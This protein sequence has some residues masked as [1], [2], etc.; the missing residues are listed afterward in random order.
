MHKV[1]VGDKIKILVDRAARAIV[2]KGEVLKVIE[3]YEN[4]HEGLF[5]AQTKDGN[6]WSFTNKNF[7]YKSIELVQETEQKENKMKTVVNYHLLNNS[8]VLNYGGKTLSISNDDPRYAKVIDC[9]R[10]N[11][12]EAIPG[13]VEVE[14]AF[15][16]T[17]LELRDGLL[18][19]GEVPFPIELSDRI[20]KHK[21]AGLPYGPLVKF[22][23]NLKKNPS[24]N[25][26]MMM[27]KF[28]EHNGIPLTQDG[29]FIAYRGIR[30]DFKDKRTGTFDNSPGSVCSM[31]REL[32]DDNPN[33]TCSAG[34]HVACYGYAKDFGEKL[35]EVKVNPFDVVAVPT[36]YQGTKMRTCKFEVIQ[37]CAEELNK[38]VYDE[39]KSEEELKEFDNIDEEFG[40]I[41]DAKD[42]FEQEEW[43]G[44]EPSDEEEESS[45]APVHL[46][47][48]RAP[49]VKSKAP[50]YRHAKRDKNGKFVAKK[51]KKSK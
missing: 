44:C 10:N 8:L 38:L 9:I 5:I 29:C 6:T 26:R 2:S 16:G 3:I 35:V 14:R 23:D 19:E 30:E 40:G 11:T 17:G 20:L 49:M 28:L 21:D 13:I 24:Y 43:A 1:K 33:N 39:K 4:D 47:K 41:D 31:A 34:L 51:H 32:V 22:W 12:L 37:E 15:A 48:A 18:C 7:D 42:G 25:A 45:E 46:V 36:D 27:F 50:N